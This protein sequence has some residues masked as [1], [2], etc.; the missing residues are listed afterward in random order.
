MQCQYFL[1]FK[2][3]RITYV[4]MTRSI[5]RWSGFLSGRH[6]CHGW[7]LLVKRGVTSAQWLRMVS[8][9]PFMDFCLSAWC[10]IGCSRSVDFIVIDHA[11]ITS[12][13]GIHDSI[14][15]RW[16][17]GLIIHVFLVFIAHSVVVVIIV[18]AGWRWRSFFFISFIIVQFS[19]ILVIGI[20]ITV[21]KII[22]V[23]ITLTITLRSWWEMGT[24]SVNGRL[25]KD[26][27]DK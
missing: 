16:C 7:R 4:H 9:A 12:V 8:F 18:A 5:F 22:V 6:R 1:M 17:F 10:L 24:I 20:F 25:Q 2:E 11:R 21:R 27:N 19:L 26:E 13:I 14:S 23:Q 15:S 3:K